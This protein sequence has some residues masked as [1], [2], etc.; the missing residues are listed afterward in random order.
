[1]DELLELI[2]ILGIRREENLVE[3]VV[4]IRWETH[5]EKK[6]IQ[7]DQMFRISNLEGEVDNTTIG[8]PKRTIV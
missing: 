3:E 8:E 7:R 6:S 4:D 1:M 5:I 2:G